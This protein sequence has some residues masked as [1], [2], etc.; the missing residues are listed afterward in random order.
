MTR[1]FPRVPGAVRLLRSVSGA[2]DLPSIIAGVVVVGILAAGVL[3]SIFGAVPWAQDRSAAQNLASLTVAQGAAKAVNGS[4]AGPE[5]M[6]ALGFLSSSHGMDFAAS[7]DGSCWVGVDR[8]GSG[9]YFYTI[10]GSPAE[11]LT[12]GTPPGSCLGSGGF[13]SMH[14][15]PSETCGILDDE[16]YCWAA[17]AEGPFQQ[18][19]GSLE[20]K[21]ATDV[22]VGYYHACALDS[23]GR[24][25]CWGSNPQGEL[26]NGETG[27]AEQPPAEVKG[28]LEGKRAT[29]VT[30]GTYYTCAVAE[31]RLYCW[32]AAANY[33]S[34]KP[35][36][37]DGGS[38][39]EVPV[40]AVAASQ[41]DTCVLSAAGTPYCWGSGDLSGDSNTPAAL[42]MSQVPGG[43]FSSITAHDSLGCG[44][45]SGSVYCWGR[46]A[47]G[48]EY[49]ATRFP[50]PVKG[51]ALK[52]KT[53]THIDLL[54]YTSA[55]AR[56]IEKNWYC[57]G[58]GAETAPSLKDFSVDEIN[59][60]ALSG[61]NGQ[62]VCALAAG[63]ISCSSAGESRLDPETF[64]RVA[65]P[66]SART[67]VENV[68]D[69][70][71]LAP[72]P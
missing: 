27:F 54:G 67:W 43:A 64:V 50:Y 12:P 49:S 53:V 46:G 19:G 56:D 8:S 61:W 52:G 36:L 29:S 18:V 6:E 23:G 70:G 60:D 17:G 44:I 65:A 62:R 14:A 58:D 59:A 72:V 10:D 51:D 20:G 32:G 71:R 30:A 33:Q 37:I 11:E 57:W 7:D 63:E 3:A 15:G 66:D 47:L 55:C 26:G 22:S 1:S 45:A 41:H 42:D 35:Q 16:V 9:K 13:S 69:G 40:K 31:E 34:T 39:T 25:H 24:V 5:G 21:T 2:F 28:A 38:L 4:Y 48:N 68:L